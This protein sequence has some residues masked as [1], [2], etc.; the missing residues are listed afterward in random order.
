MRKL[1]FQALILISTSLFV[2][3][4]TSYD[5]QI[6]DAMNRADWFQLDSIYKSAPKDSIMP[7]LEVFSRCLIGNRLN[8]PDVSIPAFDELFKSYTSDLGLENLLSSTA[9]FASDLSRVGYN[10]TAADL[11]RTI[12]GSTREHLDSTWA[13]SMRLCISQYDA[14]AKYHPYGITFA[15]SVGLIPFKLIAV[16]DMRNAGVLMH[17]ENSSI[18]GIDADIT[19]DT[20]AGINM[21]S[22]SMANVLGLI[23]TEGYVNVSGIGQRRGRIALAK[24]L[25][26]GNI[27][28]TDVPF[29]I[30]EMKTGNT[31]ADRYINSF[32]IVAG[33][34]L[35]LRL[36]DLTIDF[37]S[38]EITIPSEAP[39]RS[40][41]PPNMC[42]S[43][44][45]GLYTTGR[46]LGTPFLINIDT[47]DSGYG[48][49]GVEFFDA[50]KDYI[51][52]HAEA[53]TLRRG[54]IGGVVEAPCYIIKGMPVS[55]GGNTVDVT[56]LAVNTQ[57]MSTS[58]DL[59][60][61]IGLKTIMMFGKVRL[62]FVD[63]TLT[64]YPQD[65]AIY[66]D[67]SHYQ[68]L[69]PLKFQ[70]ANGPNLL[71]TI[72]FVTLGVA[73]GLLYPDA[74]INPDL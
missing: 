46:I 69:N 73:R 12:Y 37:L 40:D 24:Q 57:K 62:N 3:A 26:A 4:Q 45:M 59:G 31:K 38:K 63:F 13:E 74:S 10:R 21:I 23:P 44:D 60:C 5:R 34:E 8:R 50:N 17:L 2:V 66:Q 29:V 30:V 33:N 67:H 70:P 56:G 42:F 51:I 16:G 35:M 41:T 39:S 32:N 36:K 9:M 19:F 68:W 20:G 53:D 14:L 25:K 65:N 18:N 52:S 48:L 7:F 49:M 27:T 54:G 61:N 55:M 64:T 22:D 71:Q 6:A 43:N 15:D 11:T 72:G 28:I 47:G 58:M 1:I